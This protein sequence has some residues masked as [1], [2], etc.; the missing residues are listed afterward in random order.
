[1]Y[2][3]SW[4]R[5]RKTVIW[6]VLFLMDSTVR[7]CVKLQYVCFVWKPEHC[8]SGPI[9]L[10]SEISK[11]A[12][13][14]SQ[15]LKTVQCRAW[16]PFFFYSSQTCQIVRLHADLAA[17]RKVHLNIRVSPSTITISY[18]T[19]KVFLTT[20]HT[21]TRI[22]KHA[23]I[24]ACTD[25]LSSSSWPVIVTSS[26][27]VVPGGDWGWG[28]FTSTN[29]KERLTIIFFFAWYSDTFFVKNCS[30][31]F[32]PMRRWSNSGILH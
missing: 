7:S 32:T 30:R 1:M 26:P 6:Y 20:G 3:R 27:W 12:T 4:E 19:K 29:T 23:Q 10:V 8:W 15:H 14:R 11:K 22:Q 31:W 17:N 24:P 18:T 5:R 25:S 9:L 16:R 13:N 28:T 21:H 2:R